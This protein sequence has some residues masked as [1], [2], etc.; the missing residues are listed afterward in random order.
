MKNQRNSTFY[1][2]RDV[3]RV[4]H[5]AKIRQRGVIVSCLAFSKWRGALVANSLSL[6]IKEDPKYWNA[7]ENPHSRRPE[8]VPKF[9]ATAEYS[10][11]PLWA[12]LADVSPTTHA[13]FFA[14]ISA[15]LCSIVC[16]E[17]TS[18]EVW[19][20]LKSRSSLFIRVIIARLGQRLARSNF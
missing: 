1:A 5:Q 15:Y 14:V 18:Q 6:P 11:C 9:R 7:V 13:Q 16:T 17:L 8:Y 2:R 19:L 10:M 12:T 20:A 4:A 3:R